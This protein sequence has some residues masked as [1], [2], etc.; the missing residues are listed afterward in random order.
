MLEESLVVVVAI[1]VLVGVVIVAVTV[2]VDVVLD[3]LCAFI[4]IGFVFST[5]IKP[6]NKHSIFVALTF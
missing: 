5:T 4:A 2:C 1:V 3:V 6:C